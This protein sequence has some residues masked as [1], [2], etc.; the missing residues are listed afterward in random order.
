MK[1]ILKHS[2]EAV[3]LL[4]TTN[5]M[6]DVTIVPAFNQP[7]WLIPSS[8]ILSVDE[9]DQ[10]TSIYD[11]QD[12]EVSVFHLLPQDKA[13]DKII[14]LEGN[15]SEHRLALQ[16]AGELHQ[17]QVRISDVKDIEVPENFDKTNINET[18]VPFNENVMLSYL[19]QTVMI[20]DKVYLVPDLDKIAHQL[21]DVSS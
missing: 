18:A 14:V 2:F 8:L 17:L 9:H 5:G 21:V 4:T 7:D 13:V 20:E 6:L 11:W 10:H 12:Q 15:T 19:F 16:T 1:Q 3:S